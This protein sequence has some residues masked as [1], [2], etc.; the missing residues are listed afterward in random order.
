MNGATAERPPAPVGQVLQR[1]SHLHRAFTLIELLVVI[2]IIAIL[3]A[4]LLPALSKAKDRALRS[5]CAGNLR[6][7]GLAITMYANDNRDFFPD[8]SQ[9]QDM[10]WMDARMTT[11]FYPLYLYKNTPGTGNS[12]WRKQN[13][14]IYC[15]TD[16]WHRYYESYSSVST[17][18]GYH[19]L[20]AR[21]NNSTFYNSDRL[22]EWCYRKKMGG[23]YRKA[24][25]MLDRIQSYQKG[26]MDAAVAGKAY[27]GSNHRGVGNIPV[28]ANILYEDSR[29]DW[30]K[31][32]LGNTNTIGI[33][34]RTSAYDYYFK[35]GDLGTGPW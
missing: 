27:P 4:M 8:N 28:G 32:T 31:F 30:R 9:G 7:W 29:V 35:P 15:P 22:G 26:W 25:V 14:V 11:N 17:L 2:A 18:I 16:L 1:P 5:Q 12:G 24:P 33:G 23:S 20:P 6:Q 34:C 19:W 3:A 10:A 13:D 21:V